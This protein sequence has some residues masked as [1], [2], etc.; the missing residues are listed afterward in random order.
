MKKTLYLKLAYDVS[1]ANDAQIELLK[2]YMQTGLPPD[3]QKMASFEVLV[4]DEEKQGHKMMQHVRQE[5]R[6]QDNRDT[7]KRERR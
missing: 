6:K 2:L 7:R 4:E 1:N 5:F 3:V